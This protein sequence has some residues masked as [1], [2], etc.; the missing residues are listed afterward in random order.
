MRRLRR[1]LPEGALVDCGMPAVK[2][3][4]AEV[5][6]DKQSAGIVILGSALSIVD[7]ACLLP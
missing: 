2:E 5:S 3:S 6:S 7:S 4:H 1:D